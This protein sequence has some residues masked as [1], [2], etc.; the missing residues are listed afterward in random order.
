VPIGIACSNIGDA[1][2]TSWDSLLGAVEGRRRGRR[3][4]W[5]DMVMVM[6]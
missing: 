1:F 3:L 5:R 4:Q 6:D 2:P